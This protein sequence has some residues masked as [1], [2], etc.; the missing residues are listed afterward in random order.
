[1]CLSIY[2]YVSKMTA[3]HVDD[4]DDFCVLACS[5]DRGLGDF[6]LKISFCL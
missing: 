4:V 3:D 6:L 2:N 5:S 1:M